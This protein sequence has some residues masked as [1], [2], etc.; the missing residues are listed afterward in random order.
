MEPLE[1]SLQPLV[2]GVHHAETAV[3]ARLRFDAGRAQSRKDPG[4]SLMPIG[5]D[6]DAVDHA[7]E[8]SREPGVR[9]PAPAADP[10]VANNKIKLTVRMAYGFRNIDS[11]LSLIMLRCSWLRVQ[12]PGRA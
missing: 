5:G 12:L 6:E 8:R 11:L 9:G 2:Q 10:E 3:R 4:M 1:P 7:I